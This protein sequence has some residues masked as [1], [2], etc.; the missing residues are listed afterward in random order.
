NGSWRRRPQKRRTAPE[1][2]ERGRLPGE[3]GFRSVMAEGVSPEKGLQAKGGARIPDDTRMFL[4]WEART[5]PRSPDTHFFRKGLR[6]VRQAD[7]SPSRDVRMRGFKDRTEVADV[8][9]LVEARLRPLSPEEVAL[10]EAAGRVLAAEVL[11]ETAVPAFDR[12]AMDGYALHA[13]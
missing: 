3:E 1:A 12:A 6:G 11:A 4:L 13:A 2:N 9:A 8:L 7:S 5:R 10:E